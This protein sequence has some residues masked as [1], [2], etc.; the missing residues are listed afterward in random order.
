MRLGSATSVPEAFGCESIR[1]R[2]DAKDLAMDIVDLLLAS[3]HH[4]LVFLLAATVAAEWVLI[5]PGLSGDRLSL[6]GRIDGAYGGVAI[7][8]IAVGVARVL[9]GLKGWEYYVGNH[10]FWAKMAAFVAVGLMTVQPTR[11]IIAW[12]KLPAGQPVADHDIRSV[13]GWIKAQIAVFALIPIF[14][15]AMARGIGY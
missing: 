3:A 5:R 4:L 10:A 14:A 15:A 7:A 6:L 8:V 2:N 1:F 13:R 9:F 12:R 11:R